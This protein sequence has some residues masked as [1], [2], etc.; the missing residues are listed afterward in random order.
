MGTILDDYNVNIDEAKTGAV[1]READ[2]PVVV[3]R[4]NR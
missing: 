3:N 1:K 2:I 4:Q